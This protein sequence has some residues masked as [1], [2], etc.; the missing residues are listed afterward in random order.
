MDFPLFT[1]QPL[2]VTESSMPYRTSSSY[3][4]EITINLLSA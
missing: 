4:P 3:T 2:D 1:P